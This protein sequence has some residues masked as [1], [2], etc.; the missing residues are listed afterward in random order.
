MHISL[1]LMFKIL[2]I[3]DQV[4]KAIR[5]SFEICSGFLCGFINAAIFFL[6]KNESVGINYAFNNDCQVNFD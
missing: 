2:E 5:L 6:N 3:R 1:C 4:I